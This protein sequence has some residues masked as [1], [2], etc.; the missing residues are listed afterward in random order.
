M[1][2]NQFNGKRFKSARLYRG[3]T[4]SDLAKE[5]GI[6]KQAISQYENDETQPEMS[7]WFKII[8]VLGFPRDFFYENTMPNIETFATHFR[9]LARTKKK[10]RDAQKKKGEYL[11]ILYEYLSEFVNFPEFMI[12]DIIKQNIDNPEELAMCLRNILELGEKPIPDMVYLLE[13]LGIIV[14]ALNLNILDIDAY[15][16]KLKINDDYKYLVV[17]SNDKKSYVRRNFNCAHELSHILMHSW[18]EEME[19][20]SVSKQ[21]FNELESQAD[22]F[23]GAFLL[24]KNE[25]SKDVLRKPSN[26]EYYKELKLKWK[27]SIGAM[28]IRARHLG[29]LTPYQYQYLIRQYSA[30]QWRTEEPY[31]DN[32]IMSEPMVLKS[33]TRL[34]L[35]N[36]SWSGTQFM[37]KFHSIYNISFPITEVENLLNLNKG[38][39]ETQTKQEEII[40]LKD[41]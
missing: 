16:Q 2:N 34:V 31:D 15:T 9:S 4:L 18:I 40:S 28:L 25:F 29:L 5:L 22:N 13:K 11:A 8:N 7:N 20:E 3:Y 27:V 12:N 32:L 38:E 1:M 41:H 24:P 21:Q 14:S 37:D 6:S 10:D 23:A 35:S 33:A 36:N 39:L 26:L 19:L 17:L 30:K